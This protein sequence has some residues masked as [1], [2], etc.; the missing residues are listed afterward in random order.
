MMLKNKALKNQLI[1]I[2]F[3]VLIA[4]S[5]TRDSSPRTEHK[6]PVSDLS[7]TEE[8]PIRIGGASTEILSSTYNQLGEY[9]KILSQENPSQED[10][11]S[12]IENLTP[13]ALKV[14]Y[15]ELARVDRRQLTA[16]IR[17]FQRSLL[18]I[19]KLYPETATSKG[20]DKEYLRVLFQGCDD[21][22]QNCLYLQ[23]FANDSLSAEIL[24]QLAMKS[25]NQLQE[26][27][28]QRQQLATRVTQEQDTCQLEIPG[29][30]E[31][32]PCSQAYQNIENKYL[33][34]VENLFNLIHIAM[35]IK[36]SPYVEFFNLVYIQNGNDYFSYIRSQPSGSAN[37]ELQ[38]V[39]RTRMNTALFQA[40][41]QKQG[42]GRE[43]YCD[44]MIDLQPLSFSADIDESTDRHSFRSLISEFI[45]CAF[46]RGDLNNIVK[47]YEATK[48]IEGQASALIDQKNIAQS[49]QNMNFDSRGRNLFRPQDKS[50]N[51]SLTFISQHP[52]IMRA[53]NINRTNRSDTL[54]FV[55]DNLFFEKINADIANSYWETMFTGKTNAEAERIDREIFEYIENYLRVQ[56]AYNYQVT[57][58]S[59]VLLFKEEFLRNGN[60][61]VDSF[62]HIVASLDRLRTEWTVLKNRSK[63]LM[64]FLAQKY[65][66]RYFRVTQDDLTAQKYVEL[67]SNIEYLEKNLNYFVVHP[68][69]IPLYYYMS[70]LQGAVNFELSWIRRLRQ[71]ATISTRSAMSSLLDET[72]FWN[73]IRFGDQNETPDFFQKLFGFEMALRNGLFDLFPFYLMAQDRNSMPFQESAFEEEFCQ[74]NR[75]LCQNRE[76]PS[77]QAKFK[78]ELQNYL[79][80]NNEILLFKQYTY[81]KF[82]PFL[83]SMRNALTA[84]N[85]FQRS[86]DL[87]NYLNACKDPLSYAADLSLTDF[88]NSTLG[89]DNRL[90]RI[91][92]QI[93]SFRSP[94][95]NWRN[96]ITSSERILKV[97]ESHFSGPQEYLST[98]KA[99]YREQ[100]LEELRNELDQH[101]QRLRNL[102]SSIYEIESIVFNKERNCEMI[103]ARAEL[104]RRDVLLRDNVEYYKNVHAGMAIL[105][106][107]QNQTISS[108]STSR[109]SDEIRSLF[110]HWIA[111]NKDTLGGENSAQDVQNRGEKIL[112]EMMELHL[113]EDIML[114]SQSNPGELNTQEIIT[115]AITH[116]FGVHNFDRSPFNP[117]RNGTVQWGYFIHDAPLYSENHRNINTR[118]Q[119]TSNFFTQHRFDSMMRL[120]TQLKER[121]VIADDPEVRLNERLQTNYAPGERVYLG[122]EVHIPIGDSFAT[123]ASTSYYNETKIERVNW[124]MSQTQFVKESM[125]QLAGYGDSG[126]QFVNWLGNTTHSRAGIQ[127]VI[128]RL[129]RLVDLEEVGSIEIADSDRE[130]CPKDVWGDIQATHDWLGRPLPGYERHPDCKAIRVTG[131]MVR[132][133]FI[134]LMDF[135]R[136][137]YDDTLPVLLDRDLLDW[138]MSNSRYGS[139]F[140]NLLHY[141]DDAETSKWTWFDQLFLSRYTS[142]AASSEGDGTT[143]VERINNQQPLIDLKESYKKIYNEQSHLM[144]LGS[145]PEDIGRSQVRKSMIRHITR[146]QEFEASVRRLEKSRWILPN[147]VFERTSSNLREPLLDGEWRYVTHNKRSDGTPIYLKNTQPTLEFFYSYLK[148]YNTDLE[149]AFIPTS[150]DPDYISDIDQSLPCPQRF[151]QWKEQFQMQNFELPDY[152]DYGGSDDDI[153]TE[154]RGG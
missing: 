108:N 119:I 83:S 129:R 37:R 141:R 30:S 94:I 135:L 34:E 147:I 46:E 16:I 87:N 131:K 24:Q 91:Y 96:N 75:Q 22:L 99:R 98:M 109:I 42:E 53:L 48:N 104:L 145:S 47:E 122:R 28:T 29:N 120:R 64:H 137:S 134:E 73:L 50:Y 88:Y 68:L 72:G 151:D 55:V 140:T 138:A 40:R 154:A 125:R 54:S 106:S 97:L 103:I 25:Q 82:Y 11:L 70:K 100:I 14:D 127:P 41:S 128:D 8:S 84:V 3:L 74:N 77:F 144:T 52:H 107:I 130:K 148:R 35:E 5:C 60:L 39:H 101:R 132:D 89:A 80:L 86:N 143:W 95:S 9:D 17:R 124:T 13:F 111:E 76:H 4:T 31:R 81:E 58:Y 110:L 44:Y 123:L 115:L 49:I 71:T 69:Y 149:C 118:N 79:S 90:S 63:N 142:V 45:N 114:W 121:V 112:T 59:Y 36:S 18:Y 65:D 19:L 62:S 85:R 32:L 102:E 56:V 92:G 139:V 67:K 26:L 126:R 152:G 153:W 57:L 15:L 117:D 2:C 146:I 38:R 113:I 66:N 105:N 12:I 10:L 51:Y 116:Y 133:Y 6:G 43:A 23:Y 33:N 61:R 1:L 20:L 21:N 27:K 93:A 78:S 150:S 7:R 136:L